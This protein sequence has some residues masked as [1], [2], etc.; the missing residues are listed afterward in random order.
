MSDSTPYRVAIFGAGPSGF[1]IA[2][3]LLKD[4]DLDV[5]VD[6]FDRLPAP[7]GLVRYGVAPDQQTALNLVAA[8]SDHF[9]L[10][11]FPTNTS[12]MPSV[13]FDARGLYSPFV[14]ADSLSEC[15]RRCGAPHGA[16]AV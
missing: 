9:A 11:A 2:Q 14:E 8:S 3:A 12:T 4:K 7:Y 5:R 1:Y 10:A 6:L 16:A 15:V 13:V